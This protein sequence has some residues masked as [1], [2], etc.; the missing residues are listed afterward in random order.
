[1]SPIEFDRQTAISQSARQTKHVT[2]STPFLSSCLESF[3]FGELS[4]TERVRLIERETERLGEKN[5]P[6]T[7][8]P[9]RFVIPDAGEGGG[10]G[11]L[12]VLATR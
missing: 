1:M 7:W 8:A 11:A 2:L 3:P 9:P 5:V 12:S 6:N 10:G 4:R